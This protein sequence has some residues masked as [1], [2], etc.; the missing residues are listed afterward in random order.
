MLDR[1]WIISNPV[2]KVSPVPLMMPILIG[3]VVAGGSSNTLDI[4]M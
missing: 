3:V 4:Q 1:V 2:E